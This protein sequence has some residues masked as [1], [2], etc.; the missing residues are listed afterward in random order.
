MFDDSAFTFCWLFVMWSFVARH[1]RHFFVQLVYG[2]ALPLMSNVIMYR[3]GFSA[4]G[5]DRTIWKTLYRVHTLHRDMMK[6]CWPN[7]A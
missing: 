2:G 6:N 5:S 1:T 3:I 7:V 4:S